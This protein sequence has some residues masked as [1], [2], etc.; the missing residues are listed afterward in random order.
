MRA[1]SKRASITAIPHSFALPPLELERLCLSDR[2]DHLANDFSKD[3]ETSGND[4]IADLENGARHR[5]Y[6]DLSRHF[7][8]RKKCP[9]QQNETHRL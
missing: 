3:L 7:F 1:S 8:A 4:G 5:I 9:V 2:L 6:P